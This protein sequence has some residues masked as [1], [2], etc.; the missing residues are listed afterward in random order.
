MMKSLGDLA[1][2]LVETVSERLHGNAAPKPSDLAVQ[3]RKANAFILKDDGETPNN[4]RYPVIL[5]RS[6]L[7]LSD[8][9]DPA[10]LFEQLFDRNGWQPAWRD[11][12]YDFNHF[13]TGCH[14]VLGIARGHARVRLGG[15]LGRTIELRAGDVLAM[16]AGTG[17]RRLSKSRD[18]LVVGAYPPGG[19]YDEPR[20][21]DVDIAKARNAIAGVPVPEMD[22]VYGVHGALLRL[23]RPAN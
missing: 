6:P 3:D 16:P 9:V 15:R 10:A 4:P 2:T 22:P 1:H 23:W 21:C 19:S 14:E 11:G 5:Y 18:L 13:H 8:G 12:I 20:P 7:R 17:H